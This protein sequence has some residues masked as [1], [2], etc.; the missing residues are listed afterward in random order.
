MKEKKQWMKPDCI[1]I[2]KE[3][4]REQ[5]AAST[6]SRYNLCNPGRYHPIIPPPYIRK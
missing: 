5:T 6:C 4:L 3:K 1:T 2:T